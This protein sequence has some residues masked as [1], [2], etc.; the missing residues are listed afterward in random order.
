[1]ARVSTKPAAEA[2]EVPEKKPGFSVYLG[3]TKV[4][5]IQNGTILTG[6][7]TED[8]AVVMAVE[9]F[10]VIKDLI[11]PDAELARALHEIETP[12]TVLYYKYSELARM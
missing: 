4:G 3:P 1:M 12:G 6:D 7:G 11:I 10:P 9:K 5:V 8:E 2:Q